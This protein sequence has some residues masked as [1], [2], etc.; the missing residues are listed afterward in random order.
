MHRNK[1]PVPDMALVYDLVREGMRGMEDDFRVLISP[2]E[3][4]KLAARALLRGRYYFRRGK[5][6][7]ITGAFQFR[8]KRS[9]FLEY[10]AARALAGKPA[11]RM[12]PAALSLPPAHGKWRYGRRTP[13]FSTRSLQVGVQAYKDRLLQDLAPYA[14]GVPLG[15]AH[16]NPIRAE[17]WENI[18]PRGPMQTMGLLVTGDNHPSGMWDIFI[19]YSTPRGKRGLGGH[20]I[21]RNVDFV[22]DGLD[23]DVDES[24]RDRPWGSL[25]R[26]GNGRRDGFPPHMVVHIKLKASTSE[27]WHLVPK[28][29][30][31]SF[32]MRILDGAM[33]VPALRRNPTEEGGKE[34]LGPGAWGGNYGQEWAVVAGKGLKFYD[35]TAR[36]YPSEKINVDPVAWNA[37]RTLHNPPWQRT[38]LETFSGTVDN[39]KA[40]FMRAHGLNTLHVTNLNIRGGWWVQEGGA[41]KM[42]PVVTWTLVA[43]FITQHVQ[44][45]W[46]KRL[47]AGVAVQR[48]GLDKLTTA[49]V[50]RKMVDKNGPWANKHPLRSG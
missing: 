13:N 17:K 21:L 45:L 50:L 39:A 24:A 47:A 43:P 42:S 20:P 27:S 2:R 9:E 10:L 26:G 29:E 8:S 44:K 16:M 23:P 11:P 40:S 35:S 37:G 25:D 48:K 38:T 5:R 7:P 19:E 31:G 36:W 41:G 33:I 12:D 1:Q 30:R 46:Q 34:E 22:L 3:E 18:D 49:A 28:Q 32:A 15:A 6:H 4:I 14:S